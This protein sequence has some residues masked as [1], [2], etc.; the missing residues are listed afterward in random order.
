MSFNPHELGKGLSQRVQVDAQS[1]PKRGRAR[2]VAQTGW[3]QM[4]PGPRPA[5]GPNGHPSIYFFRDSE[6]LFK[7]VENVDFSWFLLGILH[8]TTI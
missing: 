6:R 7:L 3:V 5:L 8:R 4:G 2:S 1:T